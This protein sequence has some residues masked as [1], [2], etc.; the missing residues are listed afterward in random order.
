MLLTEI[1]DSLAGSELANLN[2]V[3]D[4][5]V[6]TAKIPAIVTAINLGLVKLYTRFQLK[7]RLLTLKVTST[8]LVYSLVSANA[9]SVNVGGY[10]L[11]V[12]DPFTN[13][14]IQL[15]TMTSTAGNN[16]RFDGFNGVMLLSP[17]TFRF[18]EAPD[19]DTYVIEYVARPA[20]VVYVDN[21]D[22][23]VDLP[24]AYLPPLLAYVASRFY[25]PVGIA[26]D[27]NRS[28]LD[29][30]YLQRYET[31]CQLLENKGINTG[32][33]LESDNFTQHGFI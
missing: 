14:I 12:D 4:G 23:E 27:S 32:N 26:L 10:I 3:V 29:V 33:Y 13:D 30:S 20:K 8:Q 15:L 5:A 16:I 2:C 11:D 6:L 1:L 21:T 25:S 18:A 28:S 24:D 17:K 19:D 22:I 31:E 7:R 9:V